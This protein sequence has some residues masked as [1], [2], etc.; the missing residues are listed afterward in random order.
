M[1]ADL[2]ANHGYDSD[3]FNESINKLVRVIHSTIRPHWL[4]HFLNCTGNFF[5][6]RKVE[7]NPTV[8]E[9]HKVRMIFRL[10]VT[11]NLIPLFFCEHTLRIFFR[12]LDAL[13]CLR[14][15]LNEVRNSYM[16]INTIFSLLCR[17]WHSWHSFLLTDET[18]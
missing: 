6:R 5:W 10:T 1:T 15:S 11:L 13:T 14:R 2:W 8:L 12:G 16:L 17:S 18:Q 7:E 3:L 9:Q 4:H